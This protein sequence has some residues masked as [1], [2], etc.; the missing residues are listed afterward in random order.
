VRRIE[1]HADALHGLGGMVA[2]EPP[3]NDE[4]SGHRSVGRWTRDIHRSGLPWARE[5][6]WD[7]QRRVRAGTK[8]RLYDWRHPGT[9]ADVVAAA[10]A[11]AVAAVAEVAAA[12]AA[13]A[14]AAV[15]GPRSRGART[16]APRSAR[17]R[18][19]ARASPYVVWPPWGCTRNL[20]QEGVRP[21]RIG[22][23]DL[24]GNT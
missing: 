16:S 15:S 20:Q 7:E 12:A 23:F 14:A 13:A 19:S 6:A 2:P 11:A 5:W 9:L 24:L 22:S 3:D 1:A 18:D 21:I 17:A 4:L 8:V 10:A